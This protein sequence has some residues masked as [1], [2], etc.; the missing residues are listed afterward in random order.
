MLCPTQNL[1]DEMYAS[2]SLL[3]FVPIAIIEVQFLWSASGADPEK[4][5]WTIALPLKPVKVTLFTMILYNLENSIRD[6]E[7]FLP[8]TVLL[9]Q[10]CE[11]Y[12][13]SYGSEPVS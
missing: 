13:I 3:Y 8:F 7:P 2:V 12:L 6:V 5:I 4:A 11:V 9:Q 1:S 10:S